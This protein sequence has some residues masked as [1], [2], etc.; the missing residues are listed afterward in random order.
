MSGQALSRRLAYTR[1]RK[2]TCTVDAEPCIAASWLCGASLRSRLRQRVGARLCSAQH[3]AIRPTSNRLTT[4][5]AAAYARLAAPA[6]HPAKMLA[7]QRHWWWLVCDANGHRAG[8]MRGCQVSTWSFG[9]GH[10]C[11]PQ[12]TSAVRWGS[13]SSIA[14]ASG[15]ARQLQCG[16]WEQRHSASCSLMRRGHGAGLQR[17]S[18]RASAHTSAPSTAPATRYTPPYLPAIWLW[19]GCLALPA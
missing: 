16:S 8:D 10:S 12:S 11:H 2:S 4:L 5:H 3:D 17:R 9:S 14:S 15:V 18:S 7:W 19:K 1:H 6:P 13:V